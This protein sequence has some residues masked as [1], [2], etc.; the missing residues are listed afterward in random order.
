MSALDAARAV[1]L[2][3]IKRQ[4]QAFLHKPEEGVYGDCYR[5]CIACL[6]GIDRDAVP[7]FY[8]TEDGRQSDQS[9]DWLL[10]RGYQLTQFAFQAEP[11][12]VFNV[13]QVV[14]PLTPYMLCGF[15]ATGCNHCVIALG[16]EMVWDPSLTDAGIVGAQDDGM[17]WVC[18]I[19]PIPGMALP[20]ML[21]QAA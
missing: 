12:E 4:K 2:S 3:T 14:N 11:G 7:H 15:S 10:E 16:G 13:M 20:P 9:R 21:L 18:V 6:L 1:V 17:T 5:T 8:S 19:T